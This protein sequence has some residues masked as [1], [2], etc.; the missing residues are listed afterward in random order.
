[1]ATTV[2]DQLIV[3]L[4]LD[5]REFTKGEKEV[6]ASVLRTKDTVEK[7]SKG[8]NQS[9]G[10]AVGGMNSNIGTLIKRAAVLA[11]VFKGLSVATKF[12]LEA[13]RATRQLGNDARNYDIAAAKLR[14]FQ[15]VAEMMGGSAED[16]TKTISG[17]QKAIFNLT[18]NGQMSDQLVMLSRLGVQFQ[19]S[20]G[21]ARDFNEVYLDT[22]DAI[23]RAQAAG[24]MTEG[25]AFQYLS[26]AGFDPG[27]A[28]AA[29]GGREAA[30]AQLTRQEKR[31]QVTGEDVAAAVRNEQAITS[32]GQAKEAAGVGAQRIASPI[33]TGIAGAAEHVIGLG[34]G[35]E[36]IAQTWDS[37]TKSIEPAT[38]AIVDFTEKVVGA[39]RRL[40]GRAV[41]ATATHTRG[42]RNNN[43]GNLRAVGNQKA[44]SDGFRVFGSMEEGIH[45]ANS[46]L[47][48]YAGRGNNTIAGIVGK[49]A[50]PGENNTKAYIADVVKQTGLNANQALDPSDRA[51]VLAAMFRHESGKNA[52]D[53][54]TVA[55][56]L[57]MRDG[58]LDQAERGR[59]NSS[60]GNMTK[61]D[62]GEVNV[63]TQATDANGMADAADSALK[64]KLLASHAEQGMQ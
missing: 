45:A 16:A 55:D 31:R 53:I 27:L 64:R 35:Q 42:M 61:V 15:N 46:Q 62:V 24:K 5:P 43:P 23:A 14:N 49:W 51:S 54:N 44:D 47:D 34:S 22:A 57:T 4:G 10:E 1:M 2:I 52:P 50:P 33:I 12:V 3:K 20:A 39:T 28:R 11:I 8:M 7:A 32:A 29:L 36:D 56:V 25:E 30:A 40:A 13:S 9:V 60:A 26:A 38:T 37:W 41:E 21:H 19:D 17:L 63:Y 59:Y 48:R 58:P 18:F 6:A